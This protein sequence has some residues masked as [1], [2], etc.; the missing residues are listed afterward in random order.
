VD[1]R[2]LVT[3]PADR[4][5]VNRVLVHGPCFFCFQNEPA[6]LDTLHLAGSVCGAWVAVQG[7]NLASDRMSCC[8]QPSRNSDQDKITKP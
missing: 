5:Q 8:A 7:P 3:E 4:R 2:F 6:A 1:P